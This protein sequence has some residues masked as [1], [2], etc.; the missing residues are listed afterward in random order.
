MYQEEHG[1]KPL[2]SRLKLNRIVIDPPQLEPYAHA[3]LLEAVFGKRMIW[4][5]NWAYLIP[6]LVQESA[7]EIIIPAKGRAFSQLHPVDELEHLPQLIRERIRV[8]DQKSRI[9]RLAIA[10]F[11]P[12]FDEVQPILDSLLSKQRTDPQ[13][14][15]GLYDSS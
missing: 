8:V 14:D 2:T 9:L 1:A 11:E 4:E 5:N 15:L 7:H 13:S 10:F 6:S 12:V 3:T